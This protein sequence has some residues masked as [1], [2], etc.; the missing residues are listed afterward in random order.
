M[1]VFAENNILIQLENNK[2]ALN[3][4]NQYKTTEERIYAFINN[5]YGKPDVEL[6]ELDINFIRKFDIYLR[7]THSFKINRID[8]VR[9]V[10]YLFVTPDY[11]KKLRRDSIIKGID[12]KN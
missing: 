12:G 2:Y 1:K 9:D 3:T 7:I 10:L 11:L 4:V 6:S 5:E 8:E